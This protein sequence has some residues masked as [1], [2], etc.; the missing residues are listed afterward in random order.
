MGPKSTGKGP[1]KRYMDER[2][3]DEGHVKM[4]TDFGVMWPQAKG[5][6]E[7]PEAGRSRKDPPPE[8][9]EG[10]QPC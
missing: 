8:P 2:H 5:H 6:L 3:K 7:P 10:A 9:P 4:E 1:Y